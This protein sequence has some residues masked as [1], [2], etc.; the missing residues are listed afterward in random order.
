MFV[1]NEVTKVCQLN[2]WREE[3]NMFD[4][5]CEPIAICESFSQASNF[6]DGYMQSKGYVE[7]FTEIDSPTMTVFI[8]D[9]YD[10]QDNTE[11][12]KQLCIQYVKYNLD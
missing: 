6:I 11:S 2:A 1:V 10:Y 9:I 12:F 3:S 5:Y 8:E 7:E 4:F